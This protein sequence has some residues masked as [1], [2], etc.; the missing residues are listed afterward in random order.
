MIS[1]PRQFQFSTFNKKKVTGPLCPLIAVM[2]L[3][4]GYVVILYLTVSRLFCLTFLQLLHQSLSGRLA[5]RPTLVS[6][7]CPIPNHRRSSVHNRTPPPTTHLWG[8]ARRVRLIVQSLN[9]RGNGYDGT[10]RACI[11]TEQAH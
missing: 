11:S 1:N 7:I 10:S 8:S 6:P 9:A 2:F 3:I 4:C 5:H